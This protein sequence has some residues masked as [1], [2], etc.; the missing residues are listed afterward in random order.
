[1]KTSEYEQR[2]NEINAWAKAQY[3]QGKHSEEWIELQVERM[4]D[5]LDEEYIFGK[6]G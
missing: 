1:M 3:D 4:F 6:A 2:Q 5:K